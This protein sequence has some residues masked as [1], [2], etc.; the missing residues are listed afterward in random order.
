[1]ASGVGVVIVVAGEGVRGR[2][3]QRAGNSRRRRMEK[4]GGGDEHEIDTSRRLFF[5]Y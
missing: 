3:R 1:M 5:K 4:G 2:I